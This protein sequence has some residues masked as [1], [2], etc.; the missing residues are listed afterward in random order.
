MEANEYQSQIL[1]YKDYPSEIGPFTVILSLQSNVGRLSE[2]LN[3]ILIDNHGSFDNKDKIKTLISLGDIMFDLT[4]IASDL[5]YTLN[6]VISLNL[7]KHSKSQE[8]QE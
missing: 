4:N 1:K 3:R 2:K 6:D 7:T 5:G 8:T